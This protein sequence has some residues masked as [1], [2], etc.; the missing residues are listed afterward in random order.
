MNATFTFLFLLTALSATAQTNTANVVSNSP[1]GIIQNQTNQTASIVERA[2][3]IRADCI[4]GRRLICGKIL[5]VLP[6]G[7]VIESG[8]TNLMRAPLDRSWL[9]P[10][11]VTASRAPDLIEGREP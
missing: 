8:Y 9:V 11:T 7:L 2:G 3:Q 10:G 1:P 5:K 6:D 4:Q